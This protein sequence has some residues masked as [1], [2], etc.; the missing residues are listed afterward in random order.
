MSVIP[1]KKRAK[2]KSRKSGVSSPVPPKSG[3]LT[4]VGTEKAKAVLA[5]LVDGIGS[6]TRLADDIGVLLRELTPGDRQLFE[7][8]RAEGGTLYG[9]LAGM[10]VRMITYRDAIRR[11]LA[12]GEKS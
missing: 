6:Q 8:L 11:L 7:T 4:P 2:A 9:D 12:K 3:V 1:A 5:R 10:S